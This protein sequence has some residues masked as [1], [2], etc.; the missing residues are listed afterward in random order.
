MRLAPQAEPAERDAFAAQLE[1]WRARMES[2]LAARLPDCDAVPTRLHQ[3]MRYSV[4]GGGKRVRPMLLF[5]GARTL[6]LAEAEVEAA[7]CAGVDRPVTKPTT[8][9]RPSW[10]ATHCS[11]SR[12]NY[13]PAI[14]PCPPRQ[15][16]VCD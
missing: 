3:A 2:A 10:W 13:S 5:A 9:R 14:P 4:L 12:F 11:P 8:R 7:A 1:S 16:Y 15:R 6:G